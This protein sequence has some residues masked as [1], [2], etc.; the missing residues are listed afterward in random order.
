MLLG[1]A[2]SVP[3]DIHQVLSSIFLNSLFK[4]N[5]QQAFLDP[6]YKITGHNPSIH[7]PTI[8]FFFF[9]FINSGISVPHQFTFFLEPQ[10]VIL[11]RSGVSAAIIKLIS[12]EGG[13]CRGEERGGKS[14]TTKIPIRRGKSGQIHRTP[15]EDETGTEATHLQAK[16]HQGLPVTTR[17]QKGGMEQSDLQNPA[18]TLASD[19]KAPEL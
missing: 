16:E 14:D 8:L 19:F 5:G 13:V 10:K 18:D 7:H 4:D 3:R 2:P 15:S 9:F 1:D 12:G 6:L 17:S 11:S